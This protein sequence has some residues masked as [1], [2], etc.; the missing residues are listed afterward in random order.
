MTKAN[1][2]M[3][4]INALKK[5]IKLKKNAKEKEEEVKKLWQKN[6]C[7]DQGELV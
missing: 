6:S 5:K 3:N 1:R 4:N 7:Q 2:K